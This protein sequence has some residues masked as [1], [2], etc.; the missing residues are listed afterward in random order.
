MPVYSFIFSCGH[1]LRIDS[2][3]FWLMLID[4]SPGSECTSKVALVIFSSARKIYRP[5][6]SFDTLVLWNALWS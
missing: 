1:K 6:I 4:A 2:D 5:T 3:W